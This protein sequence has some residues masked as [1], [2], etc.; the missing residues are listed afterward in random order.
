MKGRD[1]DLLLLQYVAPIRAFSKYPPS[2]G[3][4]FPVLQAK[5]QYLFDHSAQLRSS[6]SWQGWR[7]L[8][9]LLL[10]SQKVIMDDRLVAAWDMAIGVSS[11]RAS[12]Y[13]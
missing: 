8:S 4:S 9:S 13:G 12:R 10:I 2:P 3:G 7:Y 11:T 1:D 6:S 5:G